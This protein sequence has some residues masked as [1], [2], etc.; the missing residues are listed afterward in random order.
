MALPFFLP[1]C[2]RGP[3][4]L[5]LIRSL[6]QPASRFRKEPRIVQKVGPETSD[7]TPWSQPGIYPARIDHRFEAR[8]FGADDVAALAMARLSTPPQ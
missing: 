5:L 1:S 4:H 3:W 8:D 6:F 2:K 7:G